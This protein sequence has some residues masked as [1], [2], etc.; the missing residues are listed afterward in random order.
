MLSA[1]NP[2]ASIPSIK[3]LNVFTKEMGVSPATVW[4]WRRQG[5]L[6]TVN[7]NGRPYITSEAAVAFVARVTA[8]E[9]A[10]AKP[11]PAPRRTADPVS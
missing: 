2:T 1:M 5:I 8:G 11:I 6:E 4:R 3:A 7:I 10:K 9:F